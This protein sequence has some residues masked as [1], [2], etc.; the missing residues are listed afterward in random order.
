LQVSCHADERLRGARGKVW[1]MTIHDLL[2][3][4]CRL[5]VRRL[6]KPG[7]FLAV[8]P[9]DTS[10]DAPVIL[11]PRGQLAGRIRPGEV[12]EVFVHLDSEDRPI[13]TTTLPRITLGE[14][15]FLEVADLTHFGAFFDWGLS[16]ELLVPLDEQTRELR[17]GDR[18]PV[19]LIVD[20]TG[21][22]AGTMRVSEM[23]RDPRPSSL[24]EW[25][26][27]EAWRKEAGL[28]LFVIV[29]RRYVGLLPESEPHALE[30]G[31][32]GS[33]RVARV[34][35]DGKIELSLRRHAHE[36]L[37]G[38]AERILL[39]LRRERSHLGDHSSPEAIRAVFGLS[40]KAFK[41]GVGRLL[42][43]GLVE[44]DRDGAVVARR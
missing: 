38:D 34:L 27:G 23:L 17:V 36:E 35:A 30:R 20:D 6:G 16:K 13:A 19:G 26:E 40:K 8:D 9:H 21:R 18:H 42:K 43:R 7:A 15:A 1:V 24:D 25:V 11:L 5:P 2:G 41:R 28:G 44:L 14:V 22:L 32:A 4:A 33:F 3:R 31:E 29:E 12:M 10:A 39:V 37:E